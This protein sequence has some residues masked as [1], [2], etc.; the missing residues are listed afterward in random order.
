[1][2]KIP[3]RA[4]PQPRPS[5][6]NAGNL[7]AESYYNLCQIARVTGYADPIAAFKITG[8]RIRVVRDADGNITAGRLGW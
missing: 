8:D 6:L 7:A 1:M 4:E 2:P 3:N 5:L